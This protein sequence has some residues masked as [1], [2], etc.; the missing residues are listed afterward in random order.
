MAASIIDGTQ[1]AERM[2]AEVRQQVQELAAKGCRL[3][4]AA[5][6]VGEPPASLVYARS[7][8]RRC[9]EIG[10][11]YQLVRL[12]GDTDAEGIAKAIEQ[13]NHDPAVTGIML[14]MPLPEGIDAPALQYRIDPYKDVEGVNPANIGLVFYGTPILA[15]C[16]ALAVVE[17]VNETHVPL[18]GAHAVVVG[19]GAIVGR[20]VS[21][22][23]IQREATVTACHVATRNLIEH[24]RRADLLVV[25]VGRPSLITAEHVKPG[26]VV[27]DV[28]INRVKAR[29]EAGNEV[30]RTV[31]DVDYD[32]VREVA[33]ALT[34]VPGGVGPVTVTMLL[35]NTVEA[36]RKQ[37][38]RSSS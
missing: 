23:L 3:K 27:I 26:A 11:D 20:P 19:Q 10:I 7:Q 34:P 25:A 12:P 36:A 14:H 22:F 6:L 1:I 28:G 29:D 15:P 17:L 30:S 5:V 35:R 33:G 24:T 38:A 2:R 16:T 9:E 8:A 37:R 18:R 13:L 31:G 4:L 32:S 21:V